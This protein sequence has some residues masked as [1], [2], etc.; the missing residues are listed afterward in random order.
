MNK[1]ELDIK[2]DP[3]TD[4][5]Y[6]DVHIEKVGTY[7]PNAEIVVNNQGTT[8]NINLNISISIDGLK[9]FSL[10][11]TISRKFNLVCNKSLH[12]RFDGEDGSHYYLC[13]EDQCC[14]LDSGDRSESFT[15]QISGSPSDIISALYYIE[16]EFG[17]GMV[18]SVRYVSASN[19][20][21][22]DN[23]TIIQAI[24]IARYETRL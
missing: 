21:E 14:N 11:K 15:C 12:T 17:D 13:S 24:E 3:G 5:H 16:H 2:G 22:R 23:L 7:A 10:F 6:K 9:I 20:F 1:M 18:E 8:I 19:H 4:N